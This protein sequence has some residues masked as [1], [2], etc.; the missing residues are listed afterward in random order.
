MQH[1][2]RRHKKMQRSPRLK[3]KRSPK[4][5]TKKSEKRAV[6]QRLVAHRTVNSTCPVCTGLSGGTTGQSAQRGRRKALSGCGTGLSGVHR[7]VR[8]AMGRQQR[9]DP[10]VDCQAP[11]VDCHRRQRAADVACTGHLLYNVRWCTGL[12]GAPDDRKLL[13]SVQRLVG[14]LGAINT[15]PT[16]HLKMWEPKQHTKQYSAH[17]QVLLHPSA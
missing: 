5:S 15:T 1:L 16:G 11:T 3:N 8:C 13:L 9:S 4:D 10:T 17:S 2:K 6:S 12:S 14:G 7:T